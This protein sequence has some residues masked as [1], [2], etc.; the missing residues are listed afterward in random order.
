MG[1][2][3]TAV[4]S[5]IMSLIQSLRR[6]NNFSMTLGLSAISAQPRQRWRNATF[7]VLFVFCFVFYDLIQ[8]DTR[9]VCA[10]ERVQIRLDC[11]QSLNMLKEI[12][13]I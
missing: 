10:V 8:F 2:F 11:P 3:W 13:K 4:C 7:I 9:N 1:L 12:K 6:E 5:V